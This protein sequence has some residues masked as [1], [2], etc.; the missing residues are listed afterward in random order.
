MTTVSI[1]QPCYL[2][3]LGAFDRIKKSDIHII[4]DHVHMSGE[5]NRNKI[6]TPNGFQV[7]TV[8][9]KKATNIPICDLEI[10]EDRHWQRKHSQTI[11]QNY[12]RSLNAN[13]HMPFFMD[14]YDHEHHKLT[15]V[16]YPMMNYI[17]EQWDIKTTLVKSTDMITRGSKSDLNLNLCLEAGAKVYL[18][19]PYGRT[20][21][22]EKK[23]NDHGIEIQY[24]DYASMHPT[25]K[26]AWD[27]F[28]PNMSAIDA[29]FCCEA[30]P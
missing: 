18:S 2:S 30:M 26:Q 10:A 14:L 6:R 11:R 20:Y 27:G 12:A 23:F 5:E 3:W 9:L 25:Y 21:L 22:D 15:D 24:H 1:N 16:I 13:K 8:P 28:E 29:L 7:L 17:M 19:G 4:L